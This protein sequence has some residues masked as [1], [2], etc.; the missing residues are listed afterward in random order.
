M[1]FD[2]FVD[3]LAAILLDLGVDQGVIDDIAFFCE[4]IRDD[5]LV[6]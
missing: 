4:T 5:V 3:T 1:H 2:V 6:R